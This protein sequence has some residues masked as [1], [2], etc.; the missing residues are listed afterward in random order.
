VK[1][2]PVRKPLDWQ[3]ARTR[4]AETII[5]FDTQLEINK[6]GKLDDRLK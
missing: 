5:E 1:T 4:S 2:F 6:G 3:R